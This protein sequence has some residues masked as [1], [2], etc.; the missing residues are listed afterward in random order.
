LIDHLSTAVDSLVEALE[1]APETPAMMLPSLPA[2]ERHQVLQAFNATQAPYPRERLIHRLFEHQVD[3]TPDAVAVTNEREALTYAELNRRANQLA[4]YLLDCGVRPDH[5]VGICVERGLAMVVGLLGILKAGAAYLP[6]DPNY[7][8]DRLQYMLEDAAPSL[9]LT[10][11]RLKDLLPATAT[12]MLLLDN[13]A[14]KLDRYPATNVPVDASQADATSLVYVIYTSGS[15][16]RPKGT[17]MPH[18]AVAN[19]LEFH[20]RHLPLRAQERVLQF[21]ALSFDVAFQEIFST[22]AEGGT[23]VLLEEWVRKDPLALLELLERQHIERLFAPPVIL[24]A[25]A[26]CVSTAHAPCAQLRNVIVA[27]EQ[28][29]ISPQIVAFFKLNPECRLHNHYGPTETHVVTALTLA[30][31]SERWPALPTIGRPI[32]NT[33]IYVLDAA[34]EPVPVGVIGELY[35]A[36]ANLARGYLNRPELTTER[37]VAN[38]FAAA[39]GARMYK[40]GDL[41]RWRDDGTIE[42]LGRN[43]DQVKIR[44]FRIELGEIETQL[45]RHA[46]IK[47]AVV[48]ARNDIGGEKRLV[49]YVTTRDGRSAAAEQLSADLKARL[50]DHMIPSAFVTL[51]NLPL[52]PSGKVNRRALPAPPAGAYPV[53]HYEPPLAGMEERLAN[54]WSELLGAE[55]IGRDD[56]FF[57]LGGNS[58]T[59]LRLVARVLEVFSVHLT[60]ASVFRYPMLRELT[61]LIEIS[62]RDSSEPPAAGEQEL[63]EGTIE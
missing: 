45:A 57:K 47:E 61:Q 14:S 58:L 27:G 3:L 28:L 15:T 4:R 20:R 34:L 42:Y 46:V 50:P 36:G 10:Q 54:I 23:L 5:I 44:G 24:Q 16:G 30:G 43:D 52:T 56:H 49:A 37:F 60:A 32:A 9:L 26:E 55:R 53:T 25:L 8:S 41:G 21:A 17:A 11:E 2:R 7:P 63:D 62:R 33:Q 22:L 13:E 18:G 12:T 6:L 51:Q 39:T 19:L 59:T 31:D 38:P 48:V 1:R 40:T 35:L 29:R